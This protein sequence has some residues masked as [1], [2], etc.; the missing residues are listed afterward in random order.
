M[1]GVG[2]ISYEKNG[3]GGFKSDFMF[4]ISTDAV[5]RPE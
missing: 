5:R 4:D 2:G 3:F 1:I